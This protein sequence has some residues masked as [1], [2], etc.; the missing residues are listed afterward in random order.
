MKI[1]LLLLQLAIIF[2]PG[3]I[4]TRLDARYALKSPPTD[5]GFVFRAFL[6]RLASYTPTYILYSLSG[7]QFTI[8]DISSVE[9]K[10]VLS[11]AVI[12]EIAAALAV[13]ILLGNA[14][15]EAHG[16]SRNRRADEH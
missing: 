9:D 2:L 10:P 13:G 8:V 15:I 14:D 3:L 12:R 1:D 5:N 7:W 16:Q 11:I 6:F 4:W